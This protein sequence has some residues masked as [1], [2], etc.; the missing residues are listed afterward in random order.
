ML[1]APK[2]TAL[3][4]A[5]LFVALAAFSGCSG[6][7]KKEVSDMSSGKNRL[8]REKSPY[9][10]QHADNP[11]DWY[12]W[13]EEAFAKAKAENKPIFLSIGY[14]TC[15]WCHVMEHE[16]F[17]DSTVAALMNEAFIN[18]KVDREERPDIDNIY[19]AVCQMLTGSGGWPLTIVMTP[20]GEP[21]FAAT[22][23]PKD[24]RY[25]RPGMTEVIPQLADA[26]VNRQSDIAQSTAQILE[27]LQE[28][29]KRPPST[30]SLDQATLDKAYEEFGNRF[31]ASHGGFGNA[32]KFP[33]PH[34]LL[35][36]LRYWNRTGDEKALNM[37]EVTLDK[38]ARGGIWD[39]VGYGFHR[40]STDARW[41]APHFEKMLYDQALLLMAYSEA[42]QATRKPEYERVARDIVTYVLRDMQDKKGGFYSAE[43]ADSEGIEGKFYL[44]STEELT[45]LLGE[46]DAAVLIDLYG[47]STAGNFSEEIP[48]GNI[49]HLRRPEA[50]VIKEHGITQEELAEIVESARK[51]LFEVREKRIHPYKDDKILTDW[52][53]LMITALAKAARAFDEPEFT[54]A[55]EKAMKFIM[56]S[57]RDSSG[58]LLHRYREGTAGIMGNLDDYSFVVMGLLELYEN[59]FNVDYLQAALEL[60]TIQI[61][62]FWDDVNGGF[63]FSAD[64]AEELIVRSKEVYDGAVPSGNSVAMGNLIRL[65][66][67]TADPKLEDYSDRLSKAFY[68]DVSRAP[69]AF[70]MLL[71]ALDFGIGPSYEVVIVGDPNATDTKT[72]RRALDDRFVPNKVVLLKPEGSAGK[73]LV[74]IAS[75]TESHAA[76][77]GKATAYVCK[78]YACELPTTD[79]AK[80]VEMLGAAP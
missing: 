64:G 6:D 52:N 61:D 7:N 57:L 62:R 59:T 68:G 42:Y 18:I 11:V 41:F 50:D 13:G 53:G 19:M 38:M 77:E 51:M 78:N 63:F 33:T 47:A 12:P 40:Y 44:W 48:A 16:S 9:L 28:Y 5:C 37:V 49:L 17:E 26:W 8:A 73:A 39:H 20:D 70:S 56:T 3:I 54:D 27:R 14:S 65:S 15:H 74:K 35:F 32:P 24:Q 2:M 60:N 31:D 67:F 30:E 36:L 80:M 76:I 75:F 10:L 22:Y 29:A 23:I 55:A 69:S 79:A 43:D 4:P 25:G 46:K 21:F 58:G 72:M 66:R 71:L 45:T 1:K 34:T